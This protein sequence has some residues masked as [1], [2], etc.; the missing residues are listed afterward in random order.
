[1]QQKDENQIEIVQ[2]Q[3]NRKG[4]KKMKRIISIFLVMTLAGILFVSGSLVSADESYT[5]LYVNEE[6]T[7]ISQLLQMYAWEQKASQ[8][9]MTCSL[10]DDTTDDDSIVVPQVLEC[11]EYE[12]GRLEYLV[13]A[14]N[15]SAYEEGGEVVP[16]ASTYGTYSPTYS[17]GLTYVTV[18]VRY[19]YYTEN[20][21]RY[22]S[23]SAV[24]A[25][26]N[27]KA[28]ADT[29]NIAL[30]YYLF[31]DLGLTQEWKDSKLVNSAVV[32]Q[33]Y[34]LSNPN[35]G[36]SYIL[37]SG[38]SEGLSAGAF[39]SVNDPIVIVDDNIQDD[40]PFRGIVDNNAL[41]SL[42]PEY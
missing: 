41:L 12:D 6:I 11:R 23:I 34:T 17:S 40:H 37:M 4:E 5:V 22:A 19:L 16:L 15:I 38:G 9:V 10:L 20:G 28:S 13:S 3:K 33:K 14:T 27:N 29:V 18:N 39:I 7:D 25:T 2:K 30:R 1:M 26:V 36:S 35:S 21:Q 32:G 24:S 31:K 8:Q 42:L